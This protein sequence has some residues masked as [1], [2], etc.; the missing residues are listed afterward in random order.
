MANQLIVLVLQRHTP[1]IADWIARD[2]Q[3]IYVE[4]QKASMKRSI[5]EF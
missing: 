5:T 4:P 1:I 3:L 2:G